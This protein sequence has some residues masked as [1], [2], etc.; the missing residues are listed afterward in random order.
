[1][2]VIDKTKVRIFT[3]LMMAIVLAI[4]MTFLYYTHDTITYD[5]D[6][7]KPDIV[8]PG[9]GVNF[10]VS[11]ISPGWFETGISKIVCTIWLETNDEYIFNWS[12]RSHTVK[13]GGM[14]IVGYDTTNL[15]SGGYFIMCE[16]IVYKDSCC[17]SDYTD[18]AGRHFE[19]AEVIN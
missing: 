13:P 1:M 9:D 5:V 4:F 15:T 18:R 7:Q 19:V 3:A 16:F 11:N 10:V 6:L 2:K 17:S 12:Y 8:M 14:V